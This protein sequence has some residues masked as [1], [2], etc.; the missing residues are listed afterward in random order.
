MISG[1]L[2]HHIFLN[3]EVPTAV[4]FGMLSL[5]LNPQT[6][7]KEKKIIEVNHWKSIVVKHDDET[8]EGGCFVF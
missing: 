7:R 6:V 1:H 3:F 4:T 2:K 5:F 8:V